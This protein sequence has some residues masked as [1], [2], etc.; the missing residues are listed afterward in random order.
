VSHGLAYVIDCGDGVPRQLAMA[1]VPLS[2]LRNIFITHQH[3]DHNA[4][5]GKFILLAWTA[6]LRTR[7]D[8]WGP[9]LNRMTRLFFEM[10]CVQTFV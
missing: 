6:G 5:Y 3:S 10:R 9:P 7:V 8:T 1:D 2:S 4:D